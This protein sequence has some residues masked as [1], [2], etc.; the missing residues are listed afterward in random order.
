MDDIYIRNIMDDNA[1]Y[2]SA[3]L[4]GDIIVATIININ[5]GMMFL[6]LSIFCSVRY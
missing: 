6:L 2:I 4:I 1:W 5:D 3:Q